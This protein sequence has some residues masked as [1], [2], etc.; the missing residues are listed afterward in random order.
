VGSLLFGAP[1]AVYLVRRL[2]LG[3][4]AAWRRELY[5]LGASYALSHLAT[6]AL[7]YAARWMLLAFA[8]LRDVALYDLA[9]K[10]GMALTTLVIAPFSMAWT[11][12]L[13]DVARSDRPHER[14][15]MVLKG[16]LAAL[17][18]GAIVLCALAPEAVRLVGGATYADAA[19][20]VPLV[21]T[22]FVLSGAYAFLGMGP[23]LRRSSKE[24]LAATVSAL[25]ASVASG[26][27]LVPRFGLRGAAAA[28]LVAAFVLTAVMYR[29]SQRCYPMEYPWG[30]LVRLGALYVLAAVSASAGLALSWRLAVALAFPLALMAAGVF[31]G[32]ER[33]A[34]VRLPHDLL[35]RRAEAV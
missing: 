28:S 18:C 16:L 35:S 4:D 1:S 19:G 21:A 15:A 34:L 13:F 12:G 31:E 29:G 5:A 22:G 7:A 8:T 26:A 24:G 3:I 27:V 33:R 25:A 23:A 11:T 6:I 20:I 14:F 9:Y 32:H 10:I 17:S 30:A 2:G